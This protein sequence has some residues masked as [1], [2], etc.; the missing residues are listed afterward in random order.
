MKKQQK[1]L[2]S[3]LLH[4]EFI[5]KFETYLESKN[6]DHFSLDFLMELDQIKSDIQVKTMQ[7]AEKLNQEYALAM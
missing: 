4:L 6:T 1:L 2:K 7:T 3:S 5:N